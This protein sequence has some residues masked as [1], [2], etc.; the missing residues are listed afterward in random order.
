MHLKLKVIRKLIHQNL[1]Y[2]L[3]LYRSKD[4]S[5]VSITKKLINYSSA[6]N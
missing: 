2:S 5:P 4:F 3:D 1:S 6:E